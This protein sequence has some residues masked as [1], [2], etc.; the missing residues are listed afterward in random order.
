M[1]IVHCAGAVVHMREHQHRHLR[2]Q[3]RQHA[4]GLHQ[5]QA[6]PMALAQA[7]GNIQIRRKVAALTDDDAPLWIRML[8]NPDGR[9]QHLEQIDRR[10][11]RR[12]HLVRPCANQGSDAC[13]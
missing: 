10:R 11:V 13:A 6:V 8:R 2:P 5:L 3:R 7:L 1:H 9:G 12:H 4:I